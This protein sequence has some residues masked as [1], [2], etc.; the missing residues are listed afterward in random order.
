MPTTDYKRQLIKDLKS[1][2][3]AAEYLTAA[4]EE[5]EDVFLL[6]LRDVVM[7]QGGISALA[8]RTRLNRENL[9]DVL[10][11]RG[12]PRL[13]NITVILRRLGFDLCLR[14][15]SARARTAKRAA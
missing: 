10:S 8:R 15:K 1:V 14:P 3:Y 5:G 7:A 2:R 13:K 11:A 9:Y 6:A 12:N 4:L